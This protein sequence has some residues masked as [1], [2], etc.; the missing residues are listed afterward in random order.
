[1]VGETVQVNFRWPKGLVEDLEFVAKNLK[2]QKGDWVRMTLSKTLTIEKDNLEAHIIRRYV[3]GYISEEDFFEKMGRSPEKQLMDIRSRN[4]ENTPSP[5]ESLKA[6]R[7]YM[8]E[9]I[10]LNPDDVKES[11]EEPTMHFACPH[12]LKESEIP[13]TG[14]Y[15]KEIIKNKKVICPECKMSFD[16][17]KKY[18]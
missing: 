17:V 14:D 1:M 5:V 9:S 2:V 10:G 11:E 8:F 7:K 12:C 6:T 3:K 13:I 4:L 18:I 15:F 16:F